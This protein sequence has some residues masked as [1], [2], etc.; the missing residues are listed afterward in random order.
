MLI[1]L[2]KKSWRREECVKEK[3][4]KRGKNT[5]PLCKKQNKPK[6]RRN[7]NFF[8]KI[9]LYLFIMKIIKKN[10]IKKKCH[11]KKYKEITA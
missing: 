1:H 10:R 11:G 3:I 4:R 2:K 7:W 5:A 9:L 8:Q 6:I